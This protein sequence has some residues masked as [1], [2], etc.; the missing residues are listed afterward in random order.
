[1]AREDAHVLRRRAE[2]LLVL[3]ADRERPA[4]ARLVGHLEADDGAPFVVERRRRPRDR[5]R[6]EARDVMRRLAR[7]RLAPE[8]ARREGRR[9]LLAR[10]DEVGEDRELE[11]ERPRADV[12][13]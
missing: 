7:E 10:V 4:R 8:I 13:D 5:E 2:L 6:A 11:R 12:V 9:D 3:D 1:D